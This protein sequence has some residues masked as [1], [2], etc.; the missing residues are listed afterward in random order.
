MNPSLHHFYKALQMPIYYSYRL[1]RRER[2]SFLH[3]SLYIGEANPWLY[4][5]PLPTAHVSFC[6]TKYAHR[7]GSLFHDQHY[8]FCE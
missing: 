8:Q 1:K 3:P 2:D 5:Y 4:E 7:Y 6:L